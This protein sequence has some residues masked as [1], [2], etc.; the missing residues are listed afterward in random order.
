M[1][2]KN[3]ARRQTDRGCCPKVYE[4]HRENFKA[5]ET[6]DSAPPPPHTH[7]PTMKAKARE[8]P[9]REAETT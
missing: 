3:T 1:R 2:A 9:E 4:N 7:T 6:A 5:Q 8:R